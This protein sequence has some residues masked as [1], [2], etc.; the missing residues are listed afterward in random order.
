MPGR[1]EDSGEK[2]SNLR[3]AVEGLTEAYDVFVFTDSD[4]APSRGWLTKLVTPLGNPRVGATTTYRWLIPVRR[5][6]KS[7][8]AER[9]RIGLERQR[10]HDARRTF[11]KFLLGRRDG[12]PPAECSRKSAAWRTGRAP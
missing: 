3:K 2:V 5:N 4:I 8:L 10:R 12:H 1:R 11:A 9:G 7:G 6:G